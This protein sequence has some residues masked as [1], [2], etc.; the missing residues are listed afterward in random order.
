MKLDLELLDKAIDAIDR[1][2][3]EIDETNVCHDCVAKHAMSA[4]LSVLQAGHSKGEL[5]R[6]LDDEYDKWKQI[7]FDMK[8]ME[9]DRA[10]SRLQE[11]FLN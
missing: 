6:F 1:L 9:D 8:E 2:E 3:E 10:N 11:S 5:L 4:A 7:H